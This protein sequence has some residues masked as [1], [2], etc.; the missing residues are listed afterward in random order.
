MNENRKPFWIGAFLL[1]GLMLLAGGILVLS[2]DSLWSKPVEYV[3]YFTGALDGLDVGADV[4]YRGV[5]VGSVRDI[6]LSYDRKINDVVMPVVIR[7]NSGSDN[8]PATGPQLDRSIA[9]LV[10]RGLRAQLQTPSWLSGKA[11]VALDF[12]PGQDGYMPDRDV[13]G[14]TAIP[15]V[16]SLIDQAADVLRDLADGLKEV[17]LR[18]TLESAN[19]A[20]GSLDRLLGSGELEGSL[21][22]INQLLTNINSLTGQVQQRLP[23][24]LDN[25]DA[26]SAELKGAMGEVRLAVEQA[27][28]TLEHATGVLDESQRSLGPQSEL[29]YELLETLQAVSRASKTLQRTAESIE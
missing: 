18:E 28:K 1:S 26:S 20:L 3:V 7:I 22:G 8:E 15:T 27:R 13:T 23:S 21:S 25:V 12:F 16:P 2:R 10:E 6:R 14:L 9:L 17:P 11:I 24:V 4:T 19:R 5:K 29:Q